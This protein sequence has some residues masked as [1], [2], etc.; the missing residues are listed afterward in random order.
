VPEVLEIVEVVVR[1]REDVRR[2]REW[3][4]KAEFQ[5]RHIHI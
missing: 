3:E 1:D 4:A 2:W 5:K